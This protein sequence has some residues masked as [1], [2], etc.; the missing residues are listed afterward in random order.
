MTDSSDYAGLFI[1]TTTFEALQWDLVEHGG[2]RTEAGFCTLMGPA[3]TARAGVEED[4]E[5]QDYC[6]IKTAIQILRRAGYTFTIPDDYTVVVDEE[7]RTRHDNDRED[8]YLYHRSNTIM[9]VFKT[10]H[11]ILLHVMCRCR[12]LFIRCAY[13]HLTDE[14]KV[15]L[16]RHFRLTRVDHVERVLCDDP[17]ITIIARTG[18][19]RGEISAS[20]STV[21]H[22]IKRSRVISKALVSYF[23]HVT[24]TAGP[25]I[26]LMETAR[27]WRCKG[28]GS[29]LLEE[30]E[31]Y[32]CEILQDILVDHAICF[33]VIELETEDDVGFFAR[34]KFE[35]L[36][37]FD[38]YLGKYLGE[39]SYTSD[40]DSDSDRMQV[41]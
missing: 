27:E 6:G 3:V 25:T 20:P 32:F 29:M 33:S 9:K 35:H 31:R 4:V 16:K 19:E 21:F 13:L 1:T 41:N 7:N 23:D 8:S 40:S 39:Q 5:S 37:G 22:L 34:R 10:S 24:I 18:T 38:D 15:L 30:M 12:W 11:G 2:V 28:Y 36:D 17:G 14:I 26:E